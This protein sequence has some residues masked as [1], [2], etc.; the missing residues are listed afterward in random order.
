MDEAAKNGTFP[1]SNIHPLDYGYV[2]R[3]W[4]N[5][6]RTA[7]RFRLST[8]V[9]ADGGYGWRHLYAARIPN[10]QEICRRSLE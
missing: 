3:L 4:S 1:I 5:A 2:K 8:N 10:Q 6:R 9:L 7:S